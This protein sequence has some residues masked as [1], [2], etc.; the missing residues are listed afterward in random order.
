MDFKKAFFRLSELAELGLP[1]GRTLENKLVEGVV[2]LGSD[3]PPLRTLKLGGS[4]VVARSDLIKWL[5]A[6]GGISA[7]SGGDPTPDLP[8]GETMGGNQTPTERPRRG[9]PRMSP[10]AAAAA[11]GR[12]GN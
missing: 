7:E 10:S 12:H 8:S 4:R 9:R 1:A 2:V 3:V 11:G 6:T 5:L